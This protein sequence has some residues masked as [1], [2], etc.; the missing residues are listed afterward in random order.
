MSHSSYILSIVQALAA[1]SA[2]CMLASCDSRELCYDHSHWL[3][4]RVEFDWSQAPDATPRTMVVYMFPADRAGEP[5]RYELTD[6]NGV[7]VRI[8]A[9]EY[10]AVT[11]NGDTETLIESGSAYDEFV[12]T[13]D[14]QD[15]L[16]PMRGSKLSNAPRPEGTESQ[17]VKITPDKMW[18]GRL[19]NIVL[20]P[21][22]AGQKVRFTPTLS[23]TDITVKLVNI[24]NMDYSI[25]VSAALSSLAESYHVAEG[26]HAGAD[27]T[28]PMLMEAVDDNTFI[29]RASIFGHCD[30]SREDL[31]K[32]HIL[33]IYTSN[34][35]YYN[36]DVTSQIHESP[37]HSDIEIVVDGLKLPAVG[38][39]LSPDV[40]GWDDVINQGIDM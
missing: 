29:G 28:M 10:N 15:L 31:A 12:I 26:H 18:S 14:E 7:A 36:Y 20:T 25:D 19:E 22:V 17:P 8:P 6:F 21:G 9:G 37:D 27:V 11:F 23:T 24:T 32:K 1:L 35:Y 34:K 16:A 40:D 3:D 13:T 4:L 2:M 30:V 39:G 33:T 38:T 5:Y